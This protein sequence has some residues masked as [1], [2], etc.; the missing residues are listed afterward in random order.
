MINVSS[1]LK[2]LSII[3]A[4]LYKLLNFSHCICYF[5]CNGR[6]S[7]FY[8][9]ITVDEAAALHHI[10]SQTT[11]VCAYIHASKYGQTQTWMQKTSTVP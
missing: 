10:L 6:S 11:L 3:Y 7:I 4:C 1:V 5:W 8:A 9:A 2:I